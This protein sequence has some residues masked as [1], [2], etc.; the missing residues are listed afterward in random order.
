M[1]GKM[2]TPPP[3][4]QPPPRRRYTDLGWLCAALTGP[5]TFLAIWIYCAVTYGFLFGFLLGWIPA[6]LLALVVAVAM[7]YLWPGSGSASL[8]D[9]RSFRH[10]SAFTELQRRLDCH[11]RHR[12]RL[13]VAHG[14]AQQLISPPISAPAHPR[15]RHTR[16]FARRCPSRQSRRPIP[17]QTRAAGSGESFAWREKMY[18]HGFFECL[19]RFIYSHEDDYFTGYEATLVRDH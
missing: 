9:L 15:N 11:L 12:N 10:P 16:G 19:F 7:I 6:L 5:A 2:T 8:C 1:A 17:R 3:K 18:T 4:Y 14:S 13:V